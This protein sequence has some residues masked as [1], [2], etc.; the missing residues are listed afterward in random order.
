MSQ[1]L[2]TI[3]KDLALN[4]T[5]SSVDHSNL[6]HFREMKPDSDESS[7]HK[8]IRLSQSH[9]NADRNHHF[10]CHNCIHILYI[11]NQ[12]LEHGS[13]ALALGCAE[14]GQQRFD[15]PHFRL[16][17]SGATLEESRSATV[18]PEQNIPIILASLDKN[19]G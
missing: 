13:P 7:R 10:F 6:F 17:C 12:N 2:A 3:S 15:F 14:V 9:R 1:I 19:L 5:V 11:V 8:N 18:M 16:T 4:D